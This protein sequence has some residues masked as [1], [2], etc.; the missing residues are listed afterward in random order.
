MRRSQRSRDI[1]RSCIE[2]SH[3]GLVKRSCRDLYTCEEILQRAR[4]RNP[5]G[6]FCVLDPG[7]GLLKRSCSEKISEVQG[8]QEILYRDLS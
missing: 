1:R 7:R 8:Y 2:I 3:G 4:P 5:L 6:T